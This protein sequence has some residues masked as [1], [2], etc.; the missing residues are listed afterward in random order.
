M[1]LGI[2]EVNLLGLRTIP[3]GLVFLASTPVLKIVHVDELICQL[4]LAL[5]VVENLL[6]L[7]LTLSIIM[8]VSGE[9]GRTL[10]TNLAIVPITEVDFLQTKS[11][12]LLVDGEELLAGTDKNDALRGCVVGIPT[13]IPSATMHS[14]LTFVTVEDFGLLD[15]QLGANGICNLASDISKR[16]VGE[17]PKVNLLVPV[18][19]HVPTIVLVGAG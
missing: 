7:L 3:L 4:L 5:E 17:L 10:A 2:S 9:D 14:A 8:V 15:L 19:H 11:L 12:E 16:L 18:E 6:T 13:G 1:S